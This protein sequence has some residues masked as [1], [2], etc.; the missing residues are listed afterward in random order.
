MVGG[1]CKSSVR[2]WEGRKQHVAAQADNTQNNRTGWEGVVFA[3][4][5]TY[6]HSSLEKSFSFSFPFSSSSLN[7]PVLYSKGNMKESTRKETVVK[8]TAETERQYT[9]RVRRIGRSSYRREGKRR[10]HREGREEKAQA[11]RQRRAQKKRRGF[12]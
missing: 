8:Y 9:E 1:G 3:G 6:R 11:G 5:E 2:R 12:R 10:R 4:T 7:H